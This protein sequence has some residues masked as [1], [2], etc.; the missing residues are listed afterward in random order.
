LEIAGQKKGWLTLSAVLAVISEIMAL[1]PFYIVYLLAVECW[2]PRA[3][4][5][6]I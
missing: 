4:I 3:R 1:V 2:A 5:R 6:P